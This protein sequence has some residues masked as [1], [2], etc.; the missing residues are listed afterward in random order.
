MFIAVAKQ[1]KL[2]LPLQMRIDLQYVSMSTWTI[3]TI[4]T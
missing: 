4:W 1:C 3:W 2:N